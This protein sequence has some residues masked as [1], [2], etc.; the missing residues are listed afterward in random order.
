MPAQRKIFRI[1]QMGADGAA[2]PA[3]D[4]RVSLEADSMPIE[5]GAP[6]S[7]IESGR[8]HHELLAEIKA[9]RALVEPK[10]DAQRM[11]ETY[12]VQLAEM[13]KL[14]NE[15]VII[16]TAIT[17]T[18]QEIATLHVS[19]FTGEQ[20]SRMTHELDA[21][22]NGTEQATQTILG[23]V[24]EIDGIASSMIDGEQDQEKAVGK[25]IQDRVVKVFE[26]CNFQ[27]ITGQRISKVVNTWKFIES[28]IGQMME[29]WGGI[30]A[31]KD[32]IPDAPAEPEGDDAL[33]N[34]PKLDN[35]VGHASQDDIDALFP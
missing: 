20:A 19:G 35:D 8:R 21:V 29:I 3:I 7:D 13:Q 22:V 25:E 34:G 18:K 27:D 4:F 33:L 31:F 15:L 5:A 26:A 2:D 24:E 16:H 1:E 28:H 12:Q 10:D 30:D 23:M 11:L 14:K 9:L 6:V 32:F 17:R